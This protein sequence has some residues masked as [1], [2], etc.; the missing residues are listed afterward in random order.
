IKMDNKKIKKIE[1]IILIF[2]FLLFYLTYNEFIISLPLLLVSIF[3]AIYFMPIRLIKETF[4]SK[5]D[6]FVKFLSGLVF[7]FFIIFLYLLYILKN[8][9]PQLLIVLTLIYTI[10]NISLIYYYTD[11]NQHY[12]NLHLF[13]LINQAMYFYCS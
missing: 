1:F 10:I 12:K 2:H 7:S 5:I 6:F 13:M 11:K 9:I 8:E 4:I 3:L